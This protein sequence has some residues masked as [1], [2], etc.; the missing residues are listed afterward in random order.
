MSTANT[1]SQT[2]CATLTRE[3]DD[4]VFAAPPGSRRFSKCALDRFIIQTTGAVSGVRA[5]ENITGDAAVATCVTG[6]V[7][8]F[9]WNPGPE[10][11]SVMLSYPVRLRATAVA[12]EAHGPKPR[13]SRAGRQDVLGPRALWRAHDCRRRTALVLQLAVLVGSPTAATHRPRVTLVG[14]PDEASNLAR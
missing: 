7:S 13:S 2:E 3:R 5:S 12:R 10:G 4:E 1:R 6:V 14:G 9:R 11:G 8:R